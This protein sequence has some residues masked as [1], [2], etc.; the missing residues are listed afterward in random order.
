MWQYISS[1]S[2]ID[3]QKPV[4]RQVIVAANTLEL[5]AVC[6]EAEVVDRP[7]V[8]RIF[9][10]K[11]LHLYQQIEAY[12]ELRGLGKTGRELLRENPA[13]TK[14]YHDLEQERLRADLP[15]KLEG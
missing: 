10:D 6:V 4:P 1:L 13:A 7:V 9:R 14:L 11:Y 12:G 15:R 2:D 5:V 3:P 8:M